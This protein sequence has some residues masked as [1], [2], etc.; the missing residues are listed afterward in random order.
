M[1]AIHSDPHPGLAWRALLGALVLGLAGCS[2]LQQPAR[3]AERPVPPAVEA[4][5]PDEARLYL[6]LIHKMQAGGQYYASLAYLDKYDTQF[7][8]SAQT[9]FLRATALRKVGRL[10]EAGQIYDKLAQVAD[11]AAQAHNGLGLICAENGD[12]AQAKAHFQA[13]AAKDPTNLDILNNLGYAA[14]ASGDLEAAQIALY[15]GG[16]LGPKDRRVW[17]NIAVLEI[18]RGRP[19]NAE[20]IMDHFQLDRDRRAAIQREAA[21]WSTAQVPPET[22]PT[23]QAPAPRRG[24]TSAVLLQ[25]RVTHALVPHAPAAPGCAQ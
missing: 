2:S 12:Y 24:G 20:R 25:P 1:N 5:A 6:E 8:A 21:R 23:A 17:S 7:Q 3:S 10:D 14:L 22:A 16:Q 4:K 18:L 11:Y 19:R 9:R 15:K 13:A